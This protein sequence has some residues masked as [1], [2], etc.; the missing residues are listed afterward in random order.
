MVET[1]WLVGPKANY[2]SPM[3]HDPFGT[4]EDEHESV[5]QRQFA[6]QETKS[7]LN[8]ERK[9]PSE[10]APPSRP[11]SN[12]INRKESTLGGQ[13]PFSGQNLAV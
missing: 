1:F 2:S 13:C 10:L 8:Q 9:S 3:T 4:A 5:S 11:L 7:Q 12:V 6:S